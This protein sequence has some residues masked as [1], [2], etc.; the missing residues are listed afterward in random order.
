MSTITANQ[1][2]KGSIIVGN[3]QNLLYVHDV[4]KGL[5]HE[6]EESVLGLVTFPILSE[7]LSLSGTATIPIEKSQLTNRDPGASFPNNAVIHVGGNSTSRY[8]IDQDRYAV[9]LIGNSPA[10]VIDRAETL[11]SN[12]MQAMGRYST[13]PDAGD[14]PIRTQD[15]TTATGSVVGEQQQQDAI[16][17]KKPKKAPKSKAKS[18]VD[19]PDMYLEDAY[20]EK[21][22]S[23]EVYT[24]L[25]QGR[26]KEEI[27]T[28]VE[29][30]ALTQNDD[31]EPLLKYIKGK[32]FSE[33]FEQ[34]GVDESDIYDNPVLKSVEDM[35]LADAF[36]NG[37][38]K[39]DLTVQALCEQF[40]DEEA[41][42]LDE[43]DERIVLGLNE[44]IAKVA[45]ENET[46][47][48]YPRP[49]KPNLSLTKSQAEKIRSDIQGA[50]E[51]ASKLTTYNALV[52]SLLEAKKSLYTKREDLNARGKI[53]VRHDPTIPVV[54]GI[55]DNLNAQKARIQASKP[56]PLQM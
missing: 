40:I 6:N 16:T 52:E 30:L 25:T 45:L 37:L 20:A 19:V 53:F 9:N 34:S 48:G 18:F 32:S 28:L 56:A 22:I 8:N 7:D 55:E 26:S 5:D 51:T 17:E 1:V 49:S 46:L 41:L 38:L 44:A 33:V 29:A 54:K 15:I 13:L 3:N 50:F 12:S 24:L 43:L 42:D 31:K 36:N 11:F 4:I 21:F 35:S 2:S 14:I 39:N 23:S 10:D 47:E 27:P